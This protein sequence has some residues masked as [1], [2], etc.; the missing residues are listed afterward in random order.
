MRNSNVIGLLIFAFVFLSF[1]TANSQTKWYSSSNHKIT[2]A[3]GEYTSVEKE[4]LNYFQIR[5]S[6]TPSLNDLGAI[7]IQDQPLTKAPISRH[8]VFRIYSIELNDDG[9]YNYWTIETASD[10]QTV[11]FKVDLNSAIQTI[12]MS[13]YSPVKNAGVLKQIVYYLE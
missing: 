7:T 1:G 4:Q 2:K 13:R 6:S 11:L 5:V 8:E 9:T 3:N 10:G 12:T